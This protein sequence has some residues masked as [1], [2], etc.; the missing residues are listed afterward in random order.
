MD[1]IYF[2]SRLSTNALDALPFFAIA[3]LSLASPL[4]LLLAVVGAFQLALASTKI[5]T[6]FEG[7]EFHQAGFCAKSGWS[8]VAAIAPLQIG[9]NSTQA[10]HFHQ[11]VQQFFKLLPFGA[12]A[13][14]RMIPLSHFNVEVD[15][16]LGRAFREYRP[17][18][19]NR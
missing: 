10:L 4:L 1:S 5:V 19:F 18:L 6:S 13:S 11:P 9:R 7:I 15:R 2:F 16:G 17:D 12:V 8:N 3:V 14:I